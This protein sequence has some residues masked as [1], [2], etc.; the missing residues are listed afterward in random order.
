MK[1]CYLLLGL[2]FGCA[3][4]CS[5]RFLTVDPQ[6]EFHNPYSYT[7]NNP[8]TFL[9]PNGEAS[10]TFWFR[11][12]A[13]FRDFGG[14]FG[15]DNR[16]ASLN[17]M[18]TARAKQ[19]VT[20]DTTAGSLTQ[21]SSSNKSHH[22]VLGIALGHPIATANFNHAGGGIFDFTAAMAASNP[23]TPKLLTPD[24]D[25]I[26]FVNVRET[27]SSLIINLQMLGDSF[28]NA[29]AFI[30]D[31]KDNAVFLDVFVTEGGELGPFYLLFGKGRREMIAP[32]QLTI[33]T[34]NG[35]FTG[36]RFNDVDYTIQA[37]NEKFENVGAAND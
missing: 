21:S 15:G 23:L 14:G 8:I 9:D 20:L 25:L 29:E 24:I 12:Y 26:T 1:N 13:P 10:Y 33:H 27:S 37:W 35:I 7:G 32:T 2:F 6:R 4:P 17:L 16:G 34:E 11:L 30:L 22:P 19:K 31:E 18:A 5:A 28:P 36:V 3:L